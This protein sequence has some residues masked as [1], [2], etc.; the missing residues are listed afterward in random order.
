MDTSSENTYPR[1]CLEVGLNCEACTAETGRQLAKSCK[2]LRGKMVSQL[3]IQIHPHAACAR[4][5]ANFA[6]AY[7]EAS[8]MDSNETNKTLAAVA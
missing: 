5:H 7:R 3:F 1:L 2:G 6:R 4:M 8:G